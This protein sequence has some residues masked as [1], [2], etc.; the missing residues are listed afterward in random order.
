MHNHSSVVARTVDTIKAQNAWMAKSWEV[1]YYFS[2]PNPLLAP[3]IH[4]YIKSI[5]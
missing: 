5:I 2:V 4:P 3:Q 1:F